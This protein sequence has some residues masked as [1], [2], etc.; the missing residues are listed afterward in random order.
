MDGEI[1]TSKSDPWS[2]GIHPP[3]AEESTWQ[4]PCGEA[5]AQARRV[6]RPVGPIR[7][8]HLTQDDFDPGEPR[9][10]WVGA[11][12]R[13]DHLV[14]QELIKDGADG[15]DRGARVSRLTMPL[16]GR[17]ARTIAR[18]NR[19]VDASSLETCGNPPAV[20]RIDEG[21]TK[22]RSRA[23]MLGDVGAERDDDANCFFEVES[24][25]RRAPSFHSRSAA[26][27]RGSSGPSEA[28]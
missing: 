8:Q 2:S 24:V 3:A 5:P 17:K 16:F 13:A 1:S 19:S 6:V 23:V 10:I 7:D 28:A 4:G 11:A 27:W 25:A 15:E 21:W 12:C 9:K 26:S 18:D 22:S 14:G 20:R